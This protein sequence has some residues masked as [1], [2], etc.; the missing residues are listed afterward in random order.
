VVA[1]NLA[2][3]L[4]SGVFGGGGVVGHDLNPHGAGRRILSGTP[5]GARTNQGQ[6]QRSP[7]S[8]HLRALLQTM[9]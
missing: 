2:D 5:S 8:F 3:L 6:P 9:L 1:E 4:E 7:R